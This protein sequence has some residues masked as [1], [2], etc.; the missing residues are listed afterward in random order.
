[1]PNF[2][3]FSERDQW[4]FYGD[5]D[6][7]GKTLSLINSVIS[8]LPKYWLNETMKSSSIK[9]HIQKYYFA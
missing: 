1:M 8:N 5:P 7:G 4:L 6:N 3:T 9:A 2:L